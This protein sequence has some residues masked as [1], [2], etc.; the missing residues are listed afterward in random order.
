MS[1]PDLNQLLDSLLPLAERMLAER[2][3]FPPFGGTMNQT[4]EIVA[5]GA[6]DVKEHPPSQNVIEIMTKTLRQRARSGQLRA[7][8]LCYDARTV[9]PGQ[10]EKCDAVCASLEHQSGE[11][12]NLIV[13]YH[14]MSGGDVQYEQKFTTLRVP[15][16][17]VPNEIPVGGWLLVL[18]FI[19][20]VSYPAIS[21]YHIFKYTIPNL[22]DS[23]VPIR[24]VVLLSV[25]AVVFIPTAAF[26]IVAG[27]RLWLVKPDAVR[28]TKRFL[29]TYLGANIGYFVMWVFWILIARPSGAVSF[30]EMG[31][32]H[33][34]GPILL[35][36]LWYSYLERSKR[37][38][39]TYL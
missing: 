10:T 37:V 30:A 5:V 16:F 33:V 9:P 25:Y 7:V 13:P 26:S 6:C 36:A 19:L 20:V 8:G 24:A 4:G 14:R 34:V 38:R 28:F 17:F 18:C 15:Q 29:L 35:V 22:L 12:V 2:G 3:E 31:W 27:L 32:G 1:H 39:A 11:A 21:L 23:H